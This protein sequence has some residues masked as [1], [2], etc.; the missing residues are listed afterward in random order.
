MSPLTHT[1]SQL[2]LRSTSKLDL[3]EQISP[4]FRIS[5][6][7][8]VNQFYSQGKLGCIRICE[9]Q[10]KLLKQPNFAL[11]FSSAQ[12]AGNGRYKRRS[13]FG[14][15]FNWIESTPKL[16]SLTNQTKLKTLLKLDS[17]CSWIRAFCKSSTLRGFSVA[18]IS[19]APRANL[20]FP[21]LKSFKRSREVDFDFLKV[22]TTCLQ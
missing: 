1:L 7:L 5:V 11:S 16:G 13:L 12:L 14:S 15:S 6:I 17:E 20:W 3:I 22:I 2:K 8:S 18:G 9:N 4:I 21:R 10:L 19:L